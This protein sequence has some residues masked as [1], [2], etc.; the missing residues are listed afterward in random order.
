MRRALWFGAAAIVATVSWG[1]IGRADAT[2]QCI[3]PHALDSRAVLRRAFLDLRGRIPTLAEYEALDTPAGA[4]DTQIEGAI[5]SDEFRIQMRAYHDALFWPN[6]STVRLTTGD[7]RLYGRADEALSTAVGRPRRY[8]GGT[9][10]D[11]T[12][13]G[14][15]EQTEFDPA[16]PGQ[17]R[18]INVPVVTEAD[19]NTYRQEGYRMVKPYWSPTTFVKVCAYDAQ[20]TLK[21]GNQSCGEMGATGRAECGCG[22]S[23]KWCYGPTTIQEL[24]MDL[25]EQ[26]ARAVDEVTVGGKPYTDL[27]LGKREH[28]SGRIN[29]WKKNLAQMGPLRVSFN[30]PDV[31]PKGGDVYDDA[32]SVTDRGPLH[33]GVLTLPAYLLKFQTNRGRA[34]RFRI[35]FM[36]EYFV[37]P[38]QATP[39][40]GC[41]ESDSD[42]TK[43]CIC[44]YCHQKLEPMAAAFGRFLEAGSTPIVEGGKYAK[45]NTAC[46]GST[47]DE[48]TRFYVTKP[49]PRAGW[50]LA[51]EFEND[52]PDYG[53]N[54]EA[55]PA[56]IAKPIIESGTFAR[57]TVE[58][59]FLE[60]MKREIRGAGDGDERAL[61]DE[62]VN[63]FVQSG[64]SFP[65]L[66][67]RIVTLR[68]YRSTR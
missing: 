33:A 57:A 63:A 65:A 34:N 47:K 26:L 29:F 53:P 23:M 32:W 22:P 58:R 2:D 50:L 13:D 19:G 4:L 46:I 44:Q 37:P 60:L 45:I 25:R 6:I 31:V 11:V 7:L 54:I 38:A 3:A 16:F 17:F 35:D 41:S 27:L 43:R 55:G 5:A 59:L 68:E 15:R 56:S 12:C 52:H 61:L 39:Q 10:N 8:R 67:K 21:V 48:C 14:A 42:L 62:L 66:V 49:G 18:P 64:H 40:A 28:A 1:H 24:A 20:E 9:N 51:Y 36:N 30:A